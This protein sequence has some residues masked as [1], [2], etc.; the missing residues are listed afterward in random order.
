MYGSSTVAD[1]YRGTGASPSATELTAPTSPASPAEQD[2]G[3]KKKDPLDPWARRKYKRFNYKGGKGGGGGGGGGGGNI[4]RMKDFSY[5]KFKTDPFEGRDIQSREFGEQAGYT[6]FEGEYTSERF[7]Y[8]ADPYRGAKFAAPSYA[9]AQQDPGYQF[10][11][12]QGQQAL[13]NA[14]AAKG[15]LR[16]GATMKGLMD[17][18]QA[19]AS[20]EYDK[21][22]GRALGEYRM[23]YGQDVEANRDQFAREAQKFG[24]NRQAALDQYDRQF[25]AH[26]ANQAGAAGAFNQRM[27]AHQMNQANELAA[28]QSNLMKYGQNLAGQQGAWDRSYMAGKDLYDYQL[29]RASAL[30]A[31]AAARAARG[32]AAANQRYNRAR[33]HWMDEVNMQ[34]YEDETRWNRM[35]ELGSTPYTQAPPAASGG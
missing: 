23:G 16:T 25:Q 32:R 2:D 1:Q 13:Q 18:N 11:L 8:S 6:P 26:Q 12:Q 33:Q 20:Q 19:A 34:R 29:G 4:G 28:R 3:G 24:M 15:M 7:G 5:E 35:G 14:A 17:Y 22:Y 30:D 31:Q 27:Q 9:Q 10:R 21:A